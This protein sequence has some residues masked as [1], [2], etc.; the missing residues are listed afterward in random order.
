MI[1]FGHPDKFLRAKLDLLEWTAKE[2]FPI[3]KEF[4]VEQK[5]TF[6]EKVD[7]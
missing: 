4:Q 3:G 6:F 1:F 7:N 5:R 2:K